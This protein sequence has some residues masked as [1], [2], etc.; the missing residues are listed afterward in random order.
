M[1]FHAA[2]L[3]GLAGSR[4]SGTGPQAPLLRSGLGTGFWTSSHFVLPAGGTG[5]LPDGD[6][7]LPPAASLPPP[8]PTAA[9]HLLSSWSPRGPGASCTSHLVVPAQGSCGVKR[10]RP[11]DRQAA[12]GSGQT[13]ERRRQTVFPKGPRRREALGAFVEHS[14]HP[15]PRSWCLGDAPTTRQRQCL[16]EALREGCPPNPGQRLSHGPERLRPRGPRLTLPPPGQASSPLLVPAKRQVSAPVVPGGSI[17]GP[18][19][20]GGGWLGW[21]DTLRHTGCRLVDGTGPNTA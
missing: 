20:T 6:C 18:P 5:S 3:R 21:R 10:P 7:P 11:P 17:S 16:Q 9:P 14:L 8:P 4:G 2:A 19:L 1:G 13:V 12:V 15:R